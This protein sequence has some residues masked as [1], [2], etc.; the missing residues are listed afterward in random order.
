MS[1]INNQRKSGKRLSRRF[2]RFRIYLLRV[3]LRL[4]L[5]IKKLPTI[6][7]TL[8]TQNPS[9]SNN[10]N[11]ENLNRSMRRMRYSALRLKR[12]NNLVREGFTYVEAVEI[13][14]LEEKSPNH[15][16]P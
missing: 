6:P 4:I 9:N 14:N 1:L 8:N 12:I 16:K 10:M 15:V 7:Q 5:I 2:G 3:M 11:Y 13:R